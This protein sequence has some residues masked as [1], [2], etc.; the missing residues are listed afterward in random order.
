VLR[1][2]DEIGDL[3]TTGRRKMPALMRGADGRYMALTRR[4]TDSVQKTATRRMF[5]S[6]QANEESERGDE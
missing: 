3:S 2:Y 5:S 4:Q 6:G 1:R